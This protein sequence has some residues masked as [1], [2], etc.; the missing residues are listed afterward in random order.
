[1][2]RNLLILIPVMIGMLASA[3]GKWDDKNKKELPP[4]TTIEAVIVK[5]YEFPMPDG[6]SWKIA[7]DV[8]AGNG[9]YTVFLGPKWVLDARGVKLSVNDKISLKG[10]NHLSN[11]K[12]NFMAIELVKDGT[13]VNIKHGPGFGRGDGMGPMKGKK[14]FGPGPGGRCN[15]CPNY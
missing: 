15:N 6:V 5:I 7:L 9:D 14:G 1:M 4:E 12:N 2:K 13:T 3:Q 8:K 11:G 10:F